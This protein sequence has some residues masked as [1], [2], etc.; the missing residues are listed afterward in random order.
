M[1]PP[2]YHTHLY[3]QA[4]CYERPRRPPRMGPTTTPPPITSSRAA[5]PGVAPGVHGA[6]NLLGV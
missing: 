5:P 4:S 2:T 3:A 1:P 6:R